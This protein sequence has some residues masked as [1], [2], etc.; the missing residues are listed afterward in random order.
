[1]KQVLGLMDC[2]NIKNYCH[3]FPQQDLLNMWN[4]FVSMCV[5]VLLLKQFEG[6][7]CTHNKLMWQKPRLSKWTNTEKNAVKMPTKITR[8]VGG[9]SKGVQLRHLK[10]IPHGFGLLKYFTLSFF[11][12]K[13]IWKHL[14][15]HAN[16]L[17]ILHGKFRHSLQVSFRCLWRIIKKPLLTRLHKVE[18]VFPILLSY[19][20]R[21]PRGLCSSY[22]QGV[23][24]RKGRDCRVSIGGRISLAFSFS[25]YSAWTGQALEHFDGIFHFEPLSFPS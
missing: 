14:K 22:K 13:K 20:R 16:C 10:K 2:F 18:E 23:T 3:K 7:K 5:C 6:G 12:L 19:T 4:D 24:V 11:F 15:K 17:K 1:M 8:W 25:R 21:Q 9:L